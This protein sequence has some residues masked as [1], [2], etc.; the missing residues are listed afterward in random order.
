[1][2]SLAGES[3]E[4]RIGRGGGVEDEVAGM[5]DVTDCTTEKGWKS[6][7]WNDRGRK[8]RSDAR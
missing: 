3:S 1:M 5:E 8:G 4:R 6:E 2:A 7:F